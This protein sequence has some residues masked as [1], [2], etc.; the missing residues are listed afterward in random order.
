MSEQSYRLRAIYE[1]M[2]VSKY[3]SGKNFAKIIERCLR[4]TNLSLKFTQGFNPHPKISFC[5]TLPVNIEGENEYLDIYFEK[6]INSDD[7]LKEI[8]KFLPEGV[9]FKRCEWI[10]FNSPSLCVIPLSAVYKIEKNGL[11]TQKLEKFGKVKENENFIELTIDRINGF[12][13]KALLEIV[14]NR[15]IIRK[16]ILNKS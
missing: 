9:L 15:R 10:F 13:H 8:N 11:E 4:R 3:I 2:G 7:F 1:K 14:K 5:P 12:S 6:E 16:I